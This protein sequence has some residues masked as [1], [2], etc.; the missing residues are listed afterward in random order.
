MYLSKPNGCKGKI[1]EGG[2]SHCET[3]AMTLSAFCNLSIASV[4]LRFFCLS[5]AVSWL[6]SSSVTAN[7]LPSKYISSAFCRSTC[8]ICCIDQMRACKKRHKDSL[9]HYSGTDIFPKHSNVKDPP[10]NSSSTKTND[11]AII[12]SCFRHGQVYFTEVLSTINVKVCFQWRKWEGEECA[13][14]CEK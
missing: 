2:E 11:R 13:K 7:L 9:M 12:L 4:W 5:F 8:W 1:A 6:T 10:Q 3:L 14:L